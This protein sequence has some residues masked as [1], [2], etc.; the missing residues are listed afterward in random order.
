MVL[1]QWL[2]EPG[3]VEPPDPIRYVVATFPDPLAVRDAMDRLAHRLYD[4]EH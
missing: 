2:R 4:M 3:D 1:T